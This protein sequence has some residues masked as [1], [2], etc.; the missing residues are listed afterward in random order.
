MHRGMWEDRN[1]HVHGKT[2]QES[3]EGARLAI[4]KR[5]KVLYDKPPKLALRSKQVTEVPLLTPLQQS[6]TRLKGWILHIEHQIRMTSLL[7]VAKMSGQISI[8]QAIK[9]MQKEIGSNKK[10]PPQCLHG[11]ELLHGSSRNAYVSP[12]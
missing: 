10:F 11:M 9:D 4:T 1:T 5:V 6:F 8:Q 3:R 2:L 12:V 7:D